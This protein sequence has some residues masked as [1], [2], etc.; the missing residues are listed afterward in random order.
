[1]KLSCSHCSRTLDLTGDPPSFC[2]YCGHSLG[3]NKQ[4]STVEFDHEAATRPP[5]DTPSPAAAA[6]PDVIGGYRLLRQIGS[7]GMGTV[8]EAEEL[9][10]RRFARS[11]KPPPM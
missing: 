6:I 2:P 4:T 5:T 10:S 3:K 7:G 11:I 9:V 8:H 1:M